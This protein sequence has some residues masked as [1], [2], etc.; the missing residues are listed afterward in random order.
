M[1]T[2]DLM[3]A[4]RNGEFEPE[5][6]KC[7]SVNDKIDLFKKYGVVISLDQYRDIEAKVASIK[8]GAESSYE[9]LQE[10]VEGNDVDTMSDIELV[11]VVGGRK[12]NEDE[13]AV[14]EVLKRMP[15]QNVKTEKVNLYGTDP[16]LLDKGWF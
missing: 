15:E 12:L 1:S 3:L 9:E 4:V 2:V 10:K 14:F 8:Q 6:K 16:Y 11:S 13:K 7:T 5:F